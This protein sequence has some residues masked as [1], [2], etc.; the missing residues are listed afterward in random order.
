MAAFGAPTVSVAL[1]RVSVKDAVDTSLLE[2]S[3]RSSRS[4]SRVIKRRKKCARLRSFCKESSNK[5]LHN[6][7]RSNDSA[8]FVDTVNRA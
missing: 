2:A 3:R 1:I 8:S 6:F 5:A 4:I 7:N